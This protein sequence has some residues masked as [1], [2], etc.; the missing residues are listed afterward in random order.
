MPS[1]NTHTLL[2][3]KLMHLH[4]HFTLLICRKAWRDPKLRSSFSRASTQTSHPTGERAVS[5]VLSS[6]MVNVSC[7]CQ[8]LFDF[9]T[10][11]CT[12]HKIYV[13]IS[14]PVVDLQVSGCGQAHSGV[15]HSWHPGAD[16][17]HRSPDGCAPLQDT[18]AHKDTHA[19]T[20]ERSLH[21]G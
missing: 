7:F 5:S 3:R 13:I 10:P 2:T 4:V 14:L 11:E 18:Q 15:P 12:N 19:S 20:D 17:T 8:P 1:G 21:G 6:S 16:I 9:E